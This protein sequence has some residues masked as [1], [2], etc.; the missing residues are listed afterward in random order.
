MEIPRFDR[1]T[2]DFIADACGQLDDKIQLNHQINQTLEQIAQAIFKSWFVDLEPVKAKIATL[3][4]GGSE[5]G[6]LLAAMQAISGTSLLD[7]DASAT[8]ASE[9][10]AR[11]QADQPEQYAELRATAELFPS[12][13]QDSELGEIPEGWGITRTEELS[14]KIAM[15]PFGSNIKVSTFVSCGVPII[16]GQHL[17]ETLLSDR[18]NK[19]ITEEHADRLR[20]SNVYPGDIIFTHAGTIGQ[21]SLIPEEAEYSRYVISQRQ[22]YLRVD[23]KKASPNF[24]LYFFRS[25][26]GQHLLLA[27]ASQVGVPSIARPSS[28]LKNIEFVSPSFELMQCFETISKSLLSMA[29]SMRNESQRLTA[30]RDALLPKLLSGELSIPDAETYLAE[31]EETANV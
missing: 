21:V 26:L 29:V 11:L 28:H 14:E 24:M 15:G 12:A 3:E 25:Y 16:S 7:A 8:G 22:F 17:K 5:E 20:N 31:A 18:N 19:F 1:Q 23:K 9:K 6:A 10:L 13:M 2:E 30:L 4:A 27:N